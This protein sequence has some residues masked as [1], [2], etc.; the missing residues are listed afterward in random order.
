MLFNGTMHQV[1]NVA[2]LKSDQKKYFKEI[3]RQ[4][5][6]TLNSKALPYENIS[7]LMED[8]AYV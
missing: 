3:C 7:E 6:L 8:F 4:L 1:S 5:N 2:D